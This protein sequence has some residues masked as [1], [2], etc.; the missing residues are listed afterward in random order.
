MWADVVPD[1]SGKINRASRKYH[2]TEIQNPFLRVQKEIPREFDDLFSAVQVLDFG[3][4]SLAI[5]LDC[6]NVLKLG[7]RA[8]QETR[9]FDAPILAQGKIEGIEYLVQPLAIANER[10]ECLYQ[11]D[12][13]IRPSGYMVTDRPLNNIGWIGSLAFEVA[14]S[15]FH[16]VVGKI[17][18]LLDP[19]SVNQT[20]TWTKR[21]TALL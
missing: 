15:E 3:K 6:G 8:P 20:P 14:D 16:R 13:A 18:F 11:F 5:L 19:E 21:N 10:L 7:Q 1:N 2:F 17:L 9:F 4:Y 12:K